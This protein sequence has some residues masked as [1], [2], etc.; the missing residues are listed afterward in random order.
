MA[1]QHDSS[2]Q[3]D[4]GAASLGDAQSSNPPADPEM[5]RD[6]PSEDDEGTER[7]PDGD[8]G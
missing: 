2:D 7:P 6:T 3:V 5:L 8:D 1:D 4:G